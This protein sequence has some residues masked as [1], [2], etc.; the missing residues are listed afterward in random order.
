MP[1]DDRPG[2]KG[3]RMLSRRPSPIRHRLPPT[4][5][6]SDTAMPSLTSPSA[7]WTLL[8]IAGLLEV[9]W[10]V[11]MKA[12]DGFSRHLYTGITLVAAGLSFWLLGL[13]LRS[14]PV[15]T[16]YAIWTGIGAVG[17]AVLGMVLFKEPVTAARIVCIAAIVGGIL[18]LKFL[19][20]AGPGS[21]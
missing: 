15:G 21:T 17:A 12:S 2:G 3:T 14:L 11:S 7:A 9:V 4:L 1:T 8:L 10:A 19:H 6:D 18:G 13:A 20:P 16:A 5:K